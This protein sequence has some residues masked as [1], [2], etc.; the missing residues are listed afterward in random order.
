MAIGVAI[1]M[2][3]FFVWL[4]IIYN[5]TKHWLRYKFGKPM[6]LTGKH[7]VM[8]IDWGSEDETMVV[9]GHMDRKGTLY[10]D[11]IV[12]HANGAYMSAKHYKDYKKRL[13]GK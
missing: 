2:N 11:N 10:V 8:G 12:R 1:G 4:C 6:V 13:L 9:T 7:S 3:K 5:N